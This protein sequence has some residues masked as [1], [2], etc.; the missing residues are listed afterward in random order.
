MSRSSDAPAEGDGFDTASFAAN[1]PRV[2]VL[3]SGR[4]SNF[5]ALAA[6]FAAG[7]IPGSIELLVVDQPEAGALHIAEKYRIPALYLERKRRRSAFARGLLRS[8]EAHRINYLFLAG[9]M[10]ILGRSVVEAY[11]GRILNIHPSLLPDFPGLE[12]HTQALAVGAKESG[13]S[14]HFVDFGVDT[15][16]V[17]LQRR[18]PVEPD[19]DEAS[20]AAR[21]LEQEHIAYPEAARRV[22]SG[23]VRMG[24][25]QDH[26]QA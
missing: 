4:G 2:A 16:P 11:W 21:I 1:S 5:G 20:L 19:D 10:R 24:D 12:P 23:E 14:V 18:V 8:L 26:E 7:E 22:L 9:F 25:L 6:A 15:G 3:A 17:I 13:C